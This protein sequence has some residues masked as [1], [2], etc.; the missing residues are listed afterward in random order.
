MK[1]PNIQK[2]KKDIEQFC[3]KHHIEKLALF[4][5]ILTS[6]FKSSSD[7]DFLVFFEKNIFLAY[8]V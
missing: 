5:S 6:D 7:V 4:G 1:K 8:L 3:S 2:N